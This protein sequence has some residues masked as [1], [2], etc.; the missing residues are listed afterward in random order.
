M[1]QI[2]GPLPTP[3]CQSTVKRRPTIDVEEGPPH[4]TSNLPAV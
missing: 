4:Q 2:S 1:K 3:P